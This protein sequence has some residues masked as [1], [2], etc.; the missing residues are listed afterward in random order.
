MTDDADSSFAAKFSGS[1][2][3]H[4]LPLPS[5]QV[6]HVPFYSISLDLHPYLELGTT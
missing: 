3:I 1:T 6:I 5:S 2:K 4:F